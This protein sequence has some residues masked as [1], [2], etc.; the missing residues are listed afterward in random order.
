MQQEIQTNARALEQSIP[1]W[2][3]SEVAKKELNEVRE[4]IVSQGIPRER[5][6]G[7]PG[8]SAGIYQAPLLVMARDA[9]L[10]RRQIDAIKAQKPLVTK[11][12]D[13][14]PPVQKPGVASSK[15]QIEG[16]EKAVLTNRQRT[17]A[18]AKH[19]AANLNATAD[20]FKAL[21]IG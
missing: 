16:R 17:T 9:M 1:A 4:F 3:D 13:G 21:G 11:K 10:Y 18:K 14:K 8:Q 7:V 20:R 15:A 2:K 19:G 5:V 6:Y 12:V